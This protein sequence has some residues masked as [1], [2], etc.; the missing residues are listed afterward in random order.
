MG[1][2]AKERDTNPCAVS[3]E[4][5]HLKGVVLLLCAALLWSLNG[6]LIKLVYRDGEGPSGVAI[7][8]YRS[9]F[10]GI[11]LFPIAAGRF[12]TLLQPRTNRSTK[13]TI[14]RLRKSASSCVVFYSLMTVCFVVANT[15]TE[16]ANAIIL[17]YTSTFWIFG[18]SPWL[19]RETPRLKDVWILGIAIVGIVIIFFGNAVTDLFGLLNALA[20]GLF[21]GLLTIMIRR[22]RDADSAAVSVFNNLGSAL[23]I[24][25]IVIWSGDLN[26]ST[27]SLWLLIFMGVVQF[28]L[29]Y[30]LY[31]LGLA[32]VRAYKAS[33]ITMVEP[34]LVPVWTFWIIGEVVPMST[35]VGGSVILTALVLF[36]LLA[37]PSAKTIR[38]QKGKVPPA[39][40]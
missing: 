12:S 10:A 24:L 27:R 14:F 35:A 38:T 33:L 5:N 23:L 20:A 16:A 13:A 32:R 4:R 6:V 11:V 15:K 39:N 2:N 1:P 18:L 34:I 29:P 19:L 17:Q 36:T 3:A 31:T 21:F 25:P 22:L 9:L 37:R 26:I 40:N 28:G 8:F 30:Y 7:A